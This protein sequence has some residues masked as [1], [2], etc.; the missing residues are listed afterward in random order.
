MNVEVEAPDLGRNNEEGTVAE[1]YFDEG[2]F[3]EQGEA[4][5]DIST[6]S[7]HVEVTAPQS[8]VLIE[9]LV[10]EEEVVHVGDP[11]AILDCAED[12]SDNDEDDDSETE[13]MDLGRSEE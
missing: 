10:D 3:V 12:L 6:R 9:R 13:Y 8:G 7:G 4:L 2:E 5:L 11:V 1:W